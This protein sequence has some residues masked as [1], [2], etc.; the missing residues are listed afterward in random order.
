MRGSAVKTP[1]TSVKISQAPPSAAA[2]ATAVASEPPRPSVV[3]SCESAEMPWKPATSTILPASSASLILVART[4]AIFAL[5]WTVSVTMPAWDP[6]SEIASCPRSWT[7]IAQRACDVL[8]LA[9]VGDGRAPELHHDE[10]A[11]GGLGVRRHL[12][13]RLV[14]RRHRLHLPAA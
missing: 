3:T 1:S 4:S 10:V 13:D 5:P 8:D 11:A 7:A 2:R 14:L 6:V 9:G 12:G